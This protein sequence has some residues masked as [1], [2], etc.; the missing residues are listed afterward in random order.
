MQLPEWTLEGHDTYDI[1]Y[2]RLL[3]DFIDG[4]PALYKLLKVLATTG[5]LLNSE[6]KQETMNLR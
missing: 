6:V 3:V 2:K 1:M 4:L 5:N